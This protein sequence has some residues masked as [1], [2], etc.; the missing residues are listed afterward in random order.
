[1]IVTNIKT[2]AAWYF[3]LEKWLSVSSYT[4]I[5]SAEAIPAT[6]VIHAQKH[7]FCKTLKVQFP[8]KHMALAPMFPLPRSTYTRAERITVFFVAIFIY[9]FLLILFY[10]LHEDT[11]KDPS[12]VPPFSQIVATGS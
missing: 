10:G 5:C 9:M 2:K 12:K 6:D 7:S 8:D 11:G 4:L 1:M 3:Y